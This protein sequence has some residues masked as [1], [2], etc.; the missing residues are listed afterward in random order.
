MNFE[1][2]FLISSLITL[3]NKENLFFIFDDYYFRTLIP[4]IKKN[5][6]IFIVI[7]ITKYNKITN[8]EMN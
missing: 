3:E 5:N 4:I 8:V 2:I 1:I 7:I 6:E